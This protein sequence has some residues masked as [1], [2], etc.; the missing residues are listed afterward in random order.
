M[1]W[2]PLAVA[3]QQVMS[4]ESSSSAFQS[5]R[6]QG[7]LNN[8]VPV[9]PLY[10]LPVVPCIATAAAPSLTEGAFVNC[11]TDL[12]GNLRTSASGGSGGT[13]SSFGAAFPATGTASGFTDGTNMQGAR[14]FDLDTDAGTQY[15]L[16]VNLRFSGAGGS[17]EA[18]TSANPVRVDPTG[19]TPQPVSAASL[20]LPTGA[21]TEATL[22]TRLAEATFT[23]RFSA[24]YLDADAIADQTTT[25]MHGQM[26]GYNGVT[27]DRLRSSIANGLAVDVT[28]IQGSVAVTNAGLTNIDVALSTRLAE[29]TFTG[30]INTLGQ[31]TMANST[32]VVLPSDQAAIPVTVLSTVASANN[33]G[34]CPSAA[35]NFTV[36]ASNA[37]RTWLAIWASPANTD[38]VY[39]KLGATATS[40][41]ARIAPGQTINFTS[42]RIY[43]GQVDAI[44]ASGTQAVCLMEL[45]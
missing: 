16:G 19:T 41:D 2:S 13:S 24:A 27:W 39:V 37:S 45:N 25:A 28:R 6:P 1:L 11:S 4:L 20:P 17:V 9:R 29:A 34:A 12:S 15:G 30:R 42:G 31:K 36:A 21:A 3:Q 22:A 43:T 38:D 8:T 7:L 5:V 23:G 33:D 35:V 14:V 18:G 44:P 10:N 32:P 26:Y 40:S